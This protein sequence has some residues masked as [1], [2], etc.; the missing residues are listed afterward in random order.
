MLL[1]ST[2]KI[3]GWPYFQGIL[4]K[5]LAIYDSYTVVRNTGPISYFYFKIK[6]DE[7]ILLEEIGRYDFLQKEDT[8]L[9]KYSLEDPSIG[10]VID[11]CYMQKH[12]GKPYCK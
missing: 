3:E 4:K 10:E 1:E 5:T 9:I 6:K 8:V 11:P 2:L 12:K 7:K